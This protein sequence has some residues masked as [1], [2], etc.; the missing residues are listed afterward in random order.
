M[1]LGAVHRWAGRPHMTAM[2]LIRNQGYG[3][4]AQAAGT[5]AGV[6]PCAAAND[7]V[8]VDVDCLRH[9]AAPRTRILQLVQL[10]LMSSHMG[11]WVA[12]GE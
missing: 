1:L 6:P 9:R 5:R 3:G 12:V 4:F 11:L 2:R 7:S 10:L 8:R